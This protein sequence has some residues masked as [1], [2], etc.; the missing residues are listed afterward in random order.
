MCVVTSS[1]LPTGT[2][3]ANTPLPFP[4]RPSRH[5]KPILGTQPHPLRWPLFRGATRNEI[6]G[7]P[8]GADTQHNGPRGRNHEHPGV[9]P[10]RPPPDS[11]G[12]VLPHATP[13]PGTCGH[14]KA[15]G[16][17]RRPASTRRP[18]RRRG[19]G[20][21][22]SPLPMRA[23]EVV[24]HLPPARR[25]PPVTT[26]TAPPPA[27]CT[28]PVDVLPRPGSYERAPTLAGGATRL[29]LQPRGTAAHDAGNSPLSFSPRFVFLCWRWARWT[30]PLPALVKV[31]NERK[32]RIRRR[33][34]N[35]L[36]AH[37]T[38]PSP[39]REDRRPVLGGHSYAPSL[40]TVVLA[41]PRKITRTIGDACGPPDSQTRAAPGLGTID[42]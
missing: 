5:Q 37:R 17:T 14:R 6:A 28:D 33:T 40:H 8:C 39:V 18:P 13:I 11:S 29:S 26:S 38:P 16:G 21:H 35:P 24:R 3:L 4:S 23:P 20:S 27:R 15:T 36:G 1:I 19:T 32:F 9:R 31:R 12:V 30:P 10:R 25:S 42:P 22:R 41:H 2:N 34:Q 7:V